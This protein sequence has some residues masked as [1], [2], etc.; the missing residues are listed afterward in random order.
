MQPTNLRKVNENGYA[1][2]K[3]QQHL[4]IAVASIHNMKMNK[5]VHF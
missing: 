4:V 1:Q 3:Q 5:L 2:Q